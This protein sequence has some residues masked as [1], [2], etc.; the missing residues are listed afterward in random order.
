MIRIIRE[1]DE[2]K[3]ALKARFALSDVQANYMLDTRLRSLRRLEEMELKAE[4]DALS[5]EKA[6]LEELARPT[7][8][9]SGRRSRGRSAS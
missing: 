9:C 5:K 7:K 3:D 8:A 4:N 6:G 1:E 2:P